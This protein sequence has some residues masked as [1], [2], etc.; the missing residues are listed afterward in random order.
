MPRHRSAR[1]ERRAGIPLMDYAREI[2]ALNS[3]VMLLSQ[4]I[5]YISRN[6]KILGR[7]L[8]ILN[9]K[10]KALESRPSALSTASGVDAA[11]IAALQEQLEELRE[12]VSANAHAISD[13]KQEIERLAETAATKERLQELKYVIDAVNPLDFVTVEQLQEALAQR[14]PRKK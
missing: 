3:A 6:E 8:I 5:N 11:G 13:L 2:R 9:K 7:N 1:A 4:K 10:L 14:A 12:R